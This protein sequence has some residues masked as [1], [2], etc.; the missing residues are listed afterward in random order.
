[1]REILFR[2]QR[3]KGREWVYGDLLHPDL[4]AGVGYCIEE[5]DKDKKNNCP[6]VDPATVGQFTGLCDKNGVRIFE[7]DVV[8]CSQHINGNFVDRLVET[9]FVEMKVGAFG[10]HRRQ[11]YYRPFKDWFDGWE[12]E[13]IGNI[14]T[15]NDLIEREECKNDRT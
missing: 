4:E 15:K 7:G 6:E 11:G 12:I 1:M 14:H 10:L 5:I 9:G 2:A 8:V 13:V 3:I